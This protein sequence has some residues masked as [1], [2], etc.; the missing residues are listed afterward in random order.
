MT[1]HRDWFYTNEPVLEGFVFMENDHALKIVGVG[2][3]KIKMFDGYVRTLQGIRHAKGLK[4]NFLSIGQLD[5]LGCKTHIEGGI[6]KVIKGFVVVIKAEKIVTN[7][8]M[9]IGDTLQEVEALVASTN[10]EET[11]M[12]WHRKLGHM[13]EHGLMILVKRNL[14]SKF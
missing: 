9:L 5:N 7:L 3:I 11:T 4:K 6:L 8:Y 1:L 14:I 10:Q 13:S 2:T 12:M